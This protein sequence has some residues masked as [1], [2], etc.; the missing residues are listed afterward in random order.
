MALAQM[1]PWLRLT[2]ITLVVLGA[3]GGTASA[4]I[5]VLKL[6]VSSKTRVS[7]TE[8]DVAYRV[9][10]RNNGAPAASVTAAVRSYANSVTV[11]GGSLAFPDMP[12]GQKVTS[13]NSFVIRTTGKTWDRSLV[14]IDFSAIS[15]P[16]AD[17]GTDQVRDVGA[18][19]LLNG[20]GSRDPFGKPLTYSWTLQSAPGGS[21]AA[22]ADADRV[23]ARFIPDVAGDYVFVL[24]VSNG[25]NSSE[26]ST[27]TVSTNSVRPVA[28]AG[29]DQ[30]VKRKSI[31]RLDGSA[32]TNLAEGPLTYAWQILEKPANSP[33]VLSDATALRP[34]LVADRRGIY[35]VHRLDTGPGGD[36]QRQPFLRPERLAAVLSLEPATP[37]S[38]P[39]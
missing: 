20:G 35:R 30:T 34:T 32:S 17:A 5:E 10:A 27:T 28:D 3:W 24:T 13:S 12:T 36:I 39:A 16:V 6:K 2:A 4:D 33:A 29:L 37:S 14:R 19:A 22:L 31:V 25:T 1:R 21:S 26:P 15:T 7:A 9:I 8:I 23:L 11:V 38:R 18:L